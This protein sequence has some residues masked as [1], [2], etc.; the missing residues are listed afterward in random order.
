M[1]FIM[2]MALLVMVA[3]F[4]AVAAHPSPYFGSLSLVVVS[5]GACV[6]LMGYG[7]TFLSLIMFLVY[8]GG[9]LVVFAYT[10]AL[11]ADSFSYTLNYPEVARYW[12]V[13]MLGVGI[14]YIKF[15]NM[16]FFKGWSLLEN[17]EDFGVCEGDAR[18]MALMYS[19]AG[20]LL[21]SSGW[22]LLL[23]LFAVLE[24]TRGHSRGPLRA[25]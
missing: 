3:G 4:G 17:F 9:M 13:Y 7:G 23:T 11:A 14:C 15:M 24:L 5:A 25:V 19:D 6:I 18:G 12:S 1:T 8:L 2:Y 21:M 10:T 22:M 16:E 20:S